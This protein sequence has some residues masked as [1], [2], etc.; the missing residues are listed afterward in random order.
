M[1]RIDTNELLS[2]NPI[3]EVIGRHVL[4]KKTGPHLK[5]TCP[6]HDDKHASLTVTPS[7]NLAKCFACGWSGDAIAFLADLKGLT[8]KEACEALGAEAVE[9][10]NAPVKRQAANTKRTVVWKQVIPAP[11]SGIVFNHYRHG[12]P[13][14]KWYYNTPDGLLAGIVCRFDTPDGKEVLPLTWCTDGK[15]SEWRWQGFDAPRPLYNLHLLKQY[16]NAS[17]LVVEG[18]KTADAAQWQLDPNKTVVTTWTGGSNAVALVDFV[19]LYGRKVVLLPDNDVQGISA[20]LHIRHLIRENVT[21]T[22]IAPLDS[23]LPKGWDVADKEWQPGELR[24]WVLSRIVDDIPANTTET[25]EPFGKPI[26]AWTFKQIG[27]DATY[28][29]GIYSD[30]DK[31]VFKQLIIEPP[32][33]ELPPPPPT[34]EEPPYLPPLS[35]DTNDSF[36]HEAYFKFLGYDKADNGQQSYYFIAKGSHQVIRL[37]ASNISSNT[38]LQLAPLSFWEE[39]FYG[40]KPFNTTAALNWIINTSNNV[41]PF[42]DKYIRGRGAWMDAGKVVI[43]AGDRLIVDGQDSPIGNFKSRYIY[44]IDEEL[45]FET[46]QPCRPPEAIKLL[47]LIKMLHWDRDINPYLLA[48]W[49]VIAPVCGALRW[50]PH[51][52]LTGAAGTGKSW[53]FQNLIRRL[54]GQTALSVQGET[55]EAGLRQLLKHDALPVVFDEAEGADKK[56]HDRMQQ[57]MA[58]MRASSAEDGGVMAKGTAGGSAKTFR[59]RSC[60]AFASIAVQISQQSDRTRVTV[61]GLRRY[62]APDKKERWEQILRSYN[63]IITDEFVSRLQ[64]R[65][66]SLLPVILRNAE[67]FANAAAA[68]LGAQ[69]T[70]D[71]LGALLAGAYSL[72]SDKV[73]TFDE[74]V[75]WVKEKDWSEER[76]LDRSADELQMLQHM[77]EQ[78]TS[79]ETS[80]GKYE[81][82]IGELIELAVGKR[83][84]EAIKAEE[85]HNRLKRLGFKYS[86][87]MLII[88]NT[89]DYIRKILKDTPWPQNHNKVL[90]RIEG[91]QKVESTRFIAGLETRAVAVPL[92][93]ALGG[94]KPKEETMPF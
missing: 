30:S 24:E 76:G 55:S 40:K 59:I 8:F 39:A 5:G 53:V 32:A 86:N 22:K 85:A 21:L 84:E 80:I 6:F 50:R 82:T 77:L 52:W 23:T 34:I 64:A 11:P 29:F 79:V 93:V 47:N 20:M 74:A 44:E 58:L 65:T 66:I 19:P 33:K 90:Q 10:K 63:D 89:A 41:G 62:T 67:T 48:G 17:V 54:L 3:D 75:K 57:V 88:S 60:F 43:H 1:N 26:E 31:W 25:L 78:L 36:N 27:G 12:Q 38:L 37:M 4:L 16:P 45:G 18:E 71:Q 35:D 92:Y 61:L 83:E 94:E 49:C 51:I 2:K 91:A 46:K 81:R 28:T 7:K 72:H 42:K 56:A 69:R 87:G 13:S 73:I 15:R 70:G 9:A 14:Q 68:E